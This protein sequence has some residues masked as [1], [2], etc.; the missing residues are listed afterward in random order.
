[1]G[2][3]LEVRGWVEANPVTRSDDRHPARHHDGRRT[4]AA[5]YGTIV[6]AAV[7]AAGGNQLRTTALAVTVVVT[8]A[9][10]WLAELYAELIGQH[11]HA[12][13]LPNRR[14]IRLS[15]ASTAPMITASFLPVISLVAARL[16]G[17]SSST[18]AWIALIVTVVLLVIY[19][20]NAGRSAGL[21]GLRLA[22]ITSIAGLLGVAMVV[23]KTLLQIHHG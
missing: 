7:I 13:R 8:L 4:A 23:L 22:A 2:Q 14:Q 12:G 19:G 9:I 3:A 1:L 21:E 15:M 20:L 5:I 6:T 10:Y 18:A 17:A 16:L 11:T